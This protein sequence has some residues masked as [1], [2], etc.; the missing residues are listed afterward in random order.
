MPAIRKVTGATPCSKTHSSAMALISH[1]LLEVITYSPLQWARIKL[2][3]PTQQNTPPPPSGS[4][5]TPNSSTSTGQCP[6]Q[7][8]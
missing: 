7:K 5:P 1:T 6:V 2:Y 3:K 8:V 4:N